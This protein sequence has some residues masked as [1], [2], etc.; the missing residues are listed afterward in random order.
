M[1]ARAAMEYQNDPVPEAEEPP[2]SRHAKPDPQTISRE[3]LASYLRSRSTV[4]VPFAGACCGVSR[5]TSYAAA[6]DG[7]LPILRLSHRLLVPTAR[8]LEMLGFEEDQ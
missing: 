1:K 7:S 3:Q 6:H 4:S 2:G 5:A 8:L